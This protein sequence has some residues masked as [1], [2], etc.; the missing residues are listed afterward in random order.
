MSVL[1]IAFSEQVWGQIM[2][3]SAQPMSC[4]TLDTRLLSWEPRRGW[5]SK[6]VFVD[7]DCEQAIRGEAGSLRPL[8]TGIVLSVA[9]AIRRM[10]GIGFETLIDDSLAKIT[11]VIQLK[12][13][14]N[15]RILSLMNDF[16]GGKWRQGHFQSFLW[17]NIAQTALS[18]RERMALINQ[19]HS[20]LVAATRN[21]R[22]TDKD[23]VGQGSEIAEVF[24]YG[25]MK[26]HF[27]ALPVVPKIFYKQNVQDNAKGADSVHIVLNEAEDDFSLWFGEAKFYNSIADARLDAVVSS[28]FA[29]LDTGKLR[30]ENAIITNVSDID[31]LVLA[32]SLRKK[33]KAALSSQIS[34]DH[35]KSKIHVPI[36]II[37][38]C[39]DTAACTGLSEEYR[40][41][42]S[43]HHTSRAETYFSKQLAGSTAI[44]KY[45][46]I[47]FHL[48][49]FPV[50]DKKAIVESFVNAVSYYKGAA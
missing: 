46:D 36:L 1:F 44:H 3:A 39:A 11:N 35:L 34:I 49:L 29:S 15:K 16:E 21:L 48:I 6:G 42:I 38:Q 19:S 13:L 40:K 37:H 45:N 8:W 26:N 5:G 22:L 31:H 41:Q 28:V 17:D 4:D 23:E 27:K 30:K 32:S 12:A 7:A 18:E 47:R 20:T 25:V 10:I 33:I 24:L 9:R 2:P 14:L 43:A 50:P